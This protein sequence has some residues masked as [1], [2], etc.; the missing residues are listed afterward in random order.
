MQI[1]GA[2]VG[3]DEDWLIS[4][5]INLDTQTGEHFLF[6]YNDVNAGVM[7]E[8]DG[9]RIYIDPI[10]LSSSYNE[11]PAD[12]ILITH[13][14]GDHYQESTIDIISTDETIIAM[15]DIV[16]AIS[17]LDNVTAVAPEDSFLVGSINIS[18]F[19]MYTFAPEGYT[20]SHPIENNYVSYL[21]D[22]DGFV[23]FHAGDSSNI[24]E[25]SQLQSKVDVAMLPLGPGCQTMTGIDV[26]N[27]LDMIKPA[28][29]IPIHYTEIGK[30]DFIAVYYVSV[31]NTGCEFLD[32][33]YY[34]T[35]EFNS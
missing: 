22:I 5:P 15:P 18:C 21:V 25:Y 33:A 23:I 4:P 12:A 6:D 29:F 17:T 13:E 10:D 20:S 27:A 16:A 24:P 11:F 34:G 19:Y 28:Y 31:G 30:E 3:G 8:A 7:I 32:L 1:D 26:V 9:L 2:V 35:I 14:H